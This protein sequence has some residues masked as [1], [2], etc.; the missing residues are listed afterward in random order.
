MMRKRSYAGIDW[1]R[2]AA[3]TAV[4]AIHTSPFADGSPLLD[5][6]LTYG[7]G[8][9]AVPFFLM[10]S[11]Y[12][13]LSPCL[14]SDDSDGGRYR[15]YLR[16]TAVLYGLS[17]LLYVP[18]I[19]YAGQFPKTAGELF[20]MVLFDG[21][22][23]HLWYFPA[24]LLGCSLTVPLV[25]RV[26]M[27]AALVVCAALY[28]IGLFGDS[29]YG[30]AKRIPLLKMFYG[31]VFSVSSYTRNGVFYAPLFLMLGV[32]LGKAGVLIRRRTAVLGFSVWTALMLMESAVTFVYGLQRHN[33]MYLSLPFVMTFLF[34][35]L[36]GFGG[37]T[38][39]WLR[40]GTL[41]VY[42]LHPLAI[43]VVRFVSGLTGA[44]ALFVDNSLAHFLAVC[45][46]SAAMAASLI[47]CER[48]WS[49]CVRRGG[50]GLK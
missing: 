34:S 17:A 2:P 11:G 20:R 4:V 22:F 3:A 16:K 5:A 47:L 39:G 9:V 18:V 37:Q 38:P 13:V 42:I 21:T 28:L 14:L 49:L 41:Y 50:R 31:A 6:V 46:L 1:F 29:Y 27:R 40:N 19:W 48:W 44:R 12:F 35:L 15:R 25:R 7:L 23:Y 26:G 24:V 10:V 30:L 45:A 43:V 8:R 32:Q 36:L 33:S